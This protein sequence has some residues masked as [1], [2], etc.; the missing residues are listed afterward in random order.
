MRTRIALIRGINI[1]GNRTLPMADLRAL[2]EGVGLANPATYIASGNVIFG[3]DDT[4]RN[5][6]DAIAGAIEKK[7]GFQ[8]S[9]MVR[10][11]HYLRKV[12]VENPFNDR[13]PKS[14]HVTLLGSRP[15]P[16]GLDVISEGEYGRDEFA[17]G[18]MAIYVCCP[19]GYGRTKLHNNFF[20]AKLKTPATTRNWRTV[21]KLI[22]IAENR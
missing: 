14:L 8:V 21:N 6:E 22:A 15:D 5:I 1:L 13:D 16:E 19:D 11:V 20:E 9:V 7:F 4:A 3:S 2:C 18:D 12:V 17:V 10:D